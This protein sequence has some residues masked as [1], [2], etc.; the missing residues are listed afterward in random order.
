[1]TLAHCIGYHAVAGTL[2][3]LPVGPGGTRRVLWLAAESS[4]KPA[5]EGNLIAALELQ[6]LAC[7]VRCRDLEAEALHDLPGKLHLLGV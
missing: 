7:F 1:V 5:L 6:H 2:R 3:P 4:E